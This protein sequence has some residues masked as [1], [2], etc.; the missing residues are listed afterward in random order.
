LARPAAGTGKVPGLLRIEPGIGEISGIEG[1]AQ[2]PVVIAGRLE[3][4]KALIAAGQTLCQGP[5][6]LRAIGKALRPP[7]RGVEDVEMILG[8][9]DPDEA[10]MYDHGKPVPVMRGLP[11]TAPS[12]CSGLYAWNAG[13][14][15]PD[16]DLGDLGTNGFRPRPP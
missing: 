1:M 15:E 5:G 2:M 12:N 4:G 7:E 13:G 9:V 14:T 11:Q 6:D 16:S 3:G 8:D 10:G